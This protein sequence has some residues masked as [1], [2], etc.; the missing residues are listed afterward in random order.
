M[1]ENKRGAQEKYDSKAGLISKTYKLRKEVVEAF[2]SACTAA[3][4]SQAGQLTKMMTEFIEGTRQQD[5]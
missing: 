4:T 3:G 2:A 1:A 5:D